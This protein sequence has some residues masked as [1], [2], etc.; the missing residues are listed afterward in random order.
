MLRPVPRIRPVDAVA[1]ALRASVLAGSPAPGDAL[2][3]EREL[4]ASL[5]VSRL[6]LRAAIARL[7]AEGLVRAR[8]GDAVR[9]LDPSRHAT[10]GVL[11]HLSVE[12]RPD[13]VRSFLELR[14]ALA[15]EAVALACERMSDEALALLREL[16]A[17][18][19]H[20]RDPMAWLERDLAI[21]RA[22]LE[23]AGNFAMVLLL[24]TL[25]GIWRARP[26]LAEALAADRDGAL[27][28]YDLAVALVERRDPTGVRDL[29]RRG[30]EALDETAL[31]RIERR[32]P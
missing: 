2:P 25:E 8:Q 3:A 17:A 10:L 13:L 28:G 30:L 32:T 15:G 22:V 9:V 26:E 11:A 14:R 6:T 27:A 23:G 20:E 4:A 12:D 5:G 21:T 29:V 19:R 1:A 16:V 31:A 7:E 18:Q 24:N